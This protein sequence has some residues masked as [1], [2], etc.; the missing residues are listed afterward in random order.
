[1]N[2]KFNSGENFTELVFENK[3]KTYGA[4]A[5]RKA[6][7]DNVTISLVMSSTFF[8]IIALI[9]VLFTTSKPDIPTFGQL[10]PEI[11]VQGREIIIPE[12]KKLVEQPKTT[13][14]PKTDTGQKTA[15][16]NKEDTS[17]KTNDQQNI[18]KTA[19]P[20]GDSANF[21]KPVITLPVVSAPVNN[22]VEKYAQVMPEMN[23]MKD[24]IR[25][26]L[27]Y[28]RVAVD[29]GTKGV[30]YV[31]F[32]VEI[33]GSITDINLLKGIGDG[34]EQ[35]A[36]RVVAMMPKWKPGLTDGKPVRVQCNLP[37]KFNLK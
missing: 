7:A 29:N 4:Y 23:G 18:S 25:D 19:N 6:Y 12:P 24:F 5:I 31:T 34:C 2:A 33:D 27:R 36:M 14:A 13:A 30:V 10:I 35:E 22:K 20:L 15:S 32:V 8:G 26:N 11:F 9:A 37:V 17:D 16:D 28:P 1:M 3:N 21:E